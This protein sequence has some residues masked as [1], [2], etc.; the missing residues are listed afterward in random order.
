MRKQ[1]I[2]V[3]IDWYY[4]CFKGG[5]PVTSM[6]NMIETLKEDFDFYVITSD[7]D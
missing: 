4:P 6:I 5:G 1:K 7:T 2:A 3:F